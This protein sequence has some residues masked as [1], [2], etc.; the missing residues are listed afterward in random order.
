MIEGNKNKMKHEFKVGNLICLKDGKVTV[1]GKDRIG[2]ISDMDEY[3]VYIITAKAAPLRWC[4]RHEQ[5]RLW[6]KIGETK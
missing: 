6:E 5:M 1:N 4:W 3:T 2:F